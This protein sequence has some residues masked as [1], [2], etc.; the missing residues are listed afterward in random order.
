M[1]SQVYENS[2]Y[3]MGKQETLKKG[4]LQIHFRTK[5]VEMTTICDLQNTYLRIFIEIIYTY[6][7]LC[8][9]LQKPFTGTLQ[10]K[11]RHLFNTIRVCV[12]QN[13]VLD[14]YKISNPKQRIKC[15]YA[16]IFKYDFNYARISR[17]CDHSMFFHSSTVI[18]FCIHYNS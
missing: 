8:S 12:T 4:I 6:T 16:N 17:K 1:P 3:T 7:Y 14:Q 15:N 5:K 2:S 10:S 13:E 11:Y 9:C 18:F